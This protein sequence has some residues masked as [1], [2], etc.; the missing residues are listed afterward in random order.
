MAT[1]SAPWPLAAAERAFQRHPDRLYL[2]CAAQGP[3][4]RAARRA[5]A[6]VAADPA[7]GW[8]GD[9]STWRPRIEALRT[10]AA[11]LFDGNVDGVA[12][13]P[14]AAHAL[15]IAAANLPLQ[16]GDSVLLLHDEFPSN[17]LPWR[18]RCLDVG[19][20]LVFARRTPGGDWTRA[21]LD[22]LASTPRI[23]VL[24]LS[25]VHWIDGT[26]VDLDRIAPA[27]RAHGARL[28]LD[29]SQSLGA[30]RVDLA[31]WQ[32]EFVASVGYKWL[33]GPYG[34]AYLWAAPRWRQ[35]GRPLE[36]GWM[37]RDGDALWQ[38]GSHGVAPLLAGARRFDADGVCD[39][40]RL[41]AAQAG[42]EQVL[43]WS[44]EGLEEALCARV[45]ALWRALRAE[46][47]GAWLPPGACAH[48]CGLRLPARAAEAIVAGLRT[49]G[50]AATWR[51]RHLRIAPHLHVSA[52][53]LAALAPRL[54]ALAH[55]AGAS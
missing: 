54:R 53:R 27:A 11:G 46:G 44:S 32:P 34:L 55:A 42:L 41:A 37:A 7:W 19:A 8:R 48:F 6:Q 14:S 25:Q 5:L 3:Q 13:V 26:Q 2:D 51:Q 31:A 33:L 47:L 20:Q 23:T 21:I 9:P 28:V 50:V 1:T 49:D 12:L 18:Q 36:H 16:A 52:R 17:V 35:H 15:S 10:L 22:A 39:A 40:A 45:D 43:A 29:L 4:L 30:L 24:A 38:V